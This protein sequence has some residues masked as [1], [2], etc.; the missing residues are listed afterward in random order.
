MNGEKNIFIESHNI[1]NLTSGLGV[2]NYELIKSLTNEDSEFKFILNLPNRNLLKEFNTNKI[3]YNKY[4]SFQRYPL[5]HIRRKLDLWHSPNQ[6]TKI[7]P[8]SSKIPYLLTIHD[9]IL[10][11]HPGRKIQLKEKIKRATAISYISNF[12]KNETQQYFDIPT[13]IPQY[14]IYNGNPV[15]EINVL[16]TQNFVPKLTQKKPFLFAIGDFQ[17][18]KNYHALIEMMT[19]LKDFNLILAGNSNNAYGEKLKEKIQKY[20]LQHQVFLTGRISAQEK[21]YYLKNCRAFLFPS[22]HEGFG[23]PIIEAMRFG[24]PV[25]L[26]NCSCIPEIGGE[27]AFYWENFDPQYMANSLNENL[28]KYDNSKAF[29]Q[30]KFIERAKIFCWTNAAKQYLEI[31]RQMLK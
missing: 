10:K 1:R 23:L 6:N 12:V 19:F 22:I 4:Y 31:Y 25:F 5:F 8:A 29:F 30:E 11:D 13:H 16:N 26:S 15:R 28:Q 24:N 9:V 17:E 27:N 2:F 20:N 14:V 7:E 3:N 21:E 18:R